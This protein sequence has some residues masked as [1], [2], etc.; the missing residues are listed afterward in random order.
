ML[1]SRRHRT[2][3]TATLLVMLI[4]LLAPVFY[5]QTP[6]P[7]QPDC[8]DKCS[9]QYAVCN[10]EIKKLPGSPDQPVSPF[11][12]GWQ[13]CSHANAIC[14]W[15]PSASS[16]SSTV[17]KAPK[18]PLSKEEQFLKDTVPEEQ[19]YYGKGYQPLGIPADAPNG[20]VSVMGGDD[21]TLALLTSPHTSRSARGCRCIKET[22]SP[23]GTRRS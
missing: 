1:S 8:S 5:A 6:C 4:P 19:S 18:K 21:V 15:P 12:K 7:P 16:S 3:L 13:A 20:T 17:P 14:Q 11:Y 9:R 2:P 10:D 22:S 23:P